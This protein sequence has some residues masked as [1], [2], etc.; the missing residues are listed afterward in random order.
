MIYLQGLYQISPPA[1]GLSYKINFFNHFRQRDEKQK[2]LNAN[3]L[4][5]YQTAQNVQPELGRI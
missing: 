5:Q 4:N 1:E 3:V 2:I